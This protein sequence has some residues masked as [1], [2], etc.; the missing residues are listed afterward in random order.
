MTAATSSPLYRIRTLGLEGPASGW[1]A[2]DPGD[3]FGDQA[4]PGEQLARADDHSLRDGVDVY[5]ITFSPSVR[6]TSPPP[7][8]NGC[9]MSLLADGRRRNLRRLQNVA[10]AIAASV[11]G[12]R[13]TSCSLGGRHQLKCLA[14]G[15]AVKQPGSFFTE[16]RQTLNPKTYIPVVGGSRSLADGQLASISLDFLDLDHDVQQDTFQKASLDPG[17]WPCITTN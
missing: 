17:S 9:C 12:G 7:V 6:T 15:R 4:T 16:T 11:P 5:G 3:P 14:A 13:R 2:C 8:N 10:A 1:S